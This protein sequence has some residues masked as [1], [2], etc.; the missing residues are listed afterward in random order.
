LKLTHTQLRAAHSKSEDILIVGKECS[1]KTTVLAE[2]IAWLIEQGAAADSIVC[3][4]ADWESAQ[5]VRD[6]LAKRLSVARR[7]LVGTHA[8]IALEV[9]RQS[10]DVMGYITKSLVML[11]FGEAEA[12]LREVAVTLGYCTDGGDWVTPFD[13]WES[14][15]QWMEAMDTSGLD[16]SEAKPYMNL[17]DRFRRRCEANNVTTPRLAVMQAENLLADEAIRLSWHRR[18][19]HLLLDDVDITTEPQDSFADALA[20]PE[21]VA[22]TESNLSLCLSDGAAHRLI[23][24]FQTPIPPS[25]LIPPTTDAF[26]VVYA[27]LRLCVNDNDE[28]AFMTLVPLLGVTDEEMAMIHKRSSSYCWSSLGTYRNEASPHPLAKMVYRCGVSTEPTTLAV[29]LS[30]IFDNLSDFPRAE[31]YKSAAWWWLNNLGVDTPIREAL[32]M[33]AVREGVSL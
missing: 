23:E 12:L 16:A 18:V 24:L 20:E 28:S 1:G 19:K 7:R 31:Q 29:A 22:Q 4:T 17:R 11:G 2:R 32:D 8:D 3:I 5:I 6:Y 13:A 15:Q 25:P 9:L 14:S 26:R 10:G 27:A 30:G 33:F 21:T